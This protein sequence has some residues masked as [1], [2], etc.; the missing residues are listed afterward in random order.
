MTVKDLLDDIEITHFA[1]IAQSG[2]YLY[3]TREEI[4]KRD[5]HDDTVKIFAFAATGEIYHLKKRD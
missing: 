4:P 5:L 1:V 2:T 3:K